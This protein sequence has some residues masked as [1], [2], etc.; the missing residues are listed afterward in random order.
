MRNPIASL[1]AAALTTGGLLLMGFFLRIG[2]M[3]DVDLSGSMALLFAASIVGLATV[4]MLVVATVMPGVASRYLVDELKL[5]MNASVLLAVAGPAGVFV[6]SIV[7]QPLVVTQPHR[8]GSW[9][10]WA[11]FGLGALAAAAAHLGAFKAQAWKNA[12]GSMLR[13]MSSMAFGSLVWAL[14]MLLVV[15][16]ALTVAAD[17]VHPQWGCKPEADFFPPVYRRRPG[18]TDRRVLSGHR[19]G[20]QARRETPCAPHRARGWPLRALRG[21]YRRGRP[22]HESYSVGRPLPGATFLAR[23]RR[24]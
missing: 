3:P 20:W 5:P 24:C 22:R 4:S 6:T 11:L 13:R 18:A 21:R 7:L 9:I 19:A 17:S 12:V 10:M 15:Q 16:A 8:L 23:P 1:T 2:F 14:G